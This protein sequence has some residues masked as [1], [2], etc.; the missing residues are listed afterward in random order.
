[1]VK[2]VIA[3]PHHPGS[4]GDHDVVQRIK[5]A[6]M[7]PLPLYFDLRDPKQ[8]EQNAQLLREADGAVIPGG[9]PYEDR[10]GFGKIPSKI[11][12]YADAIHSLI[13]RGR[14]VLAFCAGNQIAHAMKLVANDISLEENICDKDDKLVYSGF[15]D[16]RAHVKLACDPRRTAFTRS[17]K[18]DE[19]LPTIVDHGGGRFTTSSET[20]KYLMDNGLI[21]TQYSD[22]KGNVANSFPI[23]PNGSMG[24]IDAVTNPRG[25]LQV[26]MTHFERTWNALQPHR[27]NLVFQSMREYLEEG[28]PDLSRHAQPFNGDFPVKDF[29]Y[30]LTTIP[31]ELRVDVYVKMLTDDN[32]LNTARLFLGEDFQI[33]RR[34]VLSVGLQEKPTPE[35]AKKVLEE[36]AKLDFFDGIMLK[37]DLPTVTIPGY[38]ATYEVVDRTGGKITRGFTERPEIVPGM[39]VAITS[40]P[41]LN[42]TGY[43]IREMIKRS[44]FLRD[45]VTDVKAGGAWFFPDEKTRDRAL[46]ELLG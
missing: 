45:Q 40:I 30:L 41:Q 3:V 19:V 14:P 43:R 25:N 16:G 10:I 15:Y 17:F 23:S 42:P 1:M 27:A 20:L 12:S 8:L 9:F 5:E 38:A 11:R 37:K 29:D 22:Q 32:T 2:Y 18:K 34:R 39:P 21:V 24:N 35:T 28:C 6:G 13:R 36:I 4:N 46:E 44:S 26:S 31:P 33:D 7:T